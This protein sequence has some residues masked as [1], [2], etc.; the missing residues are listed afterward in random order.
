MQIEEFLQSLKK[1]YDDHIEEEIKKAYIIRMA[2]RFQEEQILM[3]KVRAQE[4]SYEQIQLSIEY[5]PIAIEARVDVLQTRRKKYAK[6]RRGDRF[7]LDL[8]NPEKQYLYHV[9]Q[10]ERTHNVYHAKRA[11]RLESLIN[12]MWRDITDQYEETEY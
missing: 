4:I 2:K 7:D 8:R 11:R 6:D 3:E 12:F 5:M 1:R 10:Y 9:I